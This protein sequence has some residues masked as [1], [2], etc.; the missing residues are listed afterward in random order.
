LGAE[1]GSYILSGIAASLLHGYTLPAGEGSFTYTGVDITFL[2]G[3]NLVA[4]LGEY[5][6]SGQDVRDAFE[7]FTLEAS[8]GA[9]NIAGQDIVLR[10]AARRLWVHQDAGSSEWTEELPKARRNVH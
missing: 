2:R 4:A 3:Y 5:A 7:A 9:Y 10:K 6:L 1:V 8:Q